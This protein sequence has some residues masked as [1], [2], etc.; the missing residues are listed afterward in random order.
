MSSI[1]TK[2]RKFIGKH[3]DELA[4]VTDVLG[5]VVSALPIEPQDK[6]KVKDALAKLERAS[7]SLADAAGRMEKETTVYSVEQMD[8]ALKGF[9]QSADGKAMILAAVRVEAQN[10]IKATAEKAKA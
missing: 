6:R 8:K 3:S 9:L 10:H 7:E 1:F 2:F 5:L 4:T